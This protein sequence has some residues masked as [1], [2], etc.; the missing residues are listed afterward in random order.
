M[1]A[2]AGKEA[3]LVIQRQEWTEGVRGLVGRWQ[4]RGSDCGWREAIGDLVRDHNR[5]VVSPGQRAQK[6]AEANKLVRAIRQGRWG[7][8]NLALGSLGAVIRRD[9][10]NDAEPNFVA[11]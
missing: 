8:G 10:V 6:G 9:G 3:L 4:V 5:A 7:M 11:R 1:P 2:P